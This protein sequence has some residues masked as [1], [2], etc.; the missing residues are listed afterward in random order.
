MGNNEEWDSLSDSLEKVEYKPVI[1]E[2]PKTVLKENNWKDEWVDMPEY[3]N[4]EIKPYKSLKIHF[5]NKEDYDFFAT[6]VEQNL[7]EKTKSLW[8]PKLIRGINGKLRYTDES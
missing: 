8:Y 7:T 1:K 2:P 4:K 5:R 3:S 6:L